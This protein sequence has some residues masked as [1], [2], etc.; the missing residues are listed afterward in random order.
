MTKLQQKNDTI[1]RYE[2]Q[3]GQFVN[4]SNSARKGEYSPQK[5]ENSQFIDMTSPQKV[6]EFNLDGS[7]EK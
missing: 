3:I 2:L 6:T 1:T 7:L 5:G 4:R